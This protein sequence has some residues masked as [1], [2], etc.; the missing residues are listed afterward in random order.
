MD[1]IKTKYAT[2]QFALEDLA[3]IRAKTTREKVPIGV[4]LCKCNFWH[5]TAQPNWKDRI[6]ALEQVIA[7][8]DILITELRIKIQKADSVVSKEIKKDARVIELIKQNS[9][10]HKKNTNLTNSNKELICQI[11]QSGKQSGTI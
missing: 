9:L 2:E 4:Y 5:L 3:R 7:Q 8:K 10:L 11:V 1:C 6:A